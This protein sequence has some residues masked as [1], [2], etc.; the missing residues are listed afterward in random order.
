MLPACGIVVSCA[1]GQGDPLGGRGNRW[2]YIFFLTFVK[3][4]Y[5]A[6]SLYIVRYTVSKYILGFMLL[7]LSVLDTVP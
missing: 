6:L 1:P 5:T 4:Y 3:C 7:I 2:L